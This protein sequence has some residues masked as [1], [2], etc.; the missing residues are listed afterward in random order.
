MCFFFAVVRSKKKIKQ[1][2][3]KVEVKKNK[4]I[5]QKKKKNLNTETKQNGKN[6]ESINKTRGKTAIRN[7]R[8]SPPP[9]HHV[10]FFPRSEREI[11][12]RTTRVKGMCLK[13][14]SLFLFLSVLFVTHTQK[15]RKINGTENKKHTDTDQ[16]EILKR[17]KSKTNKQGGWGGRFFTKLKTKK[18]KRGQS[19]FFCS[20]PQRASVV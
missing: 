5:I 6:T 3:K 4:I 10:F 18:T 15:I 13:K 20:S 11:K 2:E 14:I 16:R 19:F 7:E 12:Q 1:E 9:H 8:V 17:G